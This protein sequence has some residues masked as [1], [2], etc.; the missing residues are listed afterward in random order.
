MHSYESSSLLLFSVQVY[1]ISKANIKMANKKFST[2]KNEYEMTA[3]ANTTFVP[4]E[5]SDGVPAMH[6]DLVPIAELENREKDDVIG[7]E[8]STCA[9]DVSLDFF[10]GPSWR[11]AKAGIMNIPQIY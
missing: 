8:M 11:L 3:H 10:L 5:D 6:Y 4:C 7:T 1:C 2:L 9:E